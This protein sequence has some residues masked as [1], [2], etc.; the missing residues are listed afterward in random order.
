[1]G[2]PHGEPSLSLFEATAAFSPCERPQID[3][4]VV[5]GT[6]AARRLV[7]RLW[8]ERVFSAGPL[9]HSRRPVRHRPARED[10]Y[11]RHVAP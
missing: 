5:Q 10:Q 9:W 1:V 2:C 8:T 3:P 4:W 11:S 7:D 6:C